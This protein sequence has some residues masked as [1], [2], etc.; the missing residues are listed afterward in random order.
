MLSFI[1]HDL[2]LLLLAALLS[3]TLWLVVTIEQNPSESNWFN[4]VAVE[5]TDL[6]ANFVLRSELPVARVRVSAPRDIWL[7]RGLPTERLKAT[8]DASKVGPGVNDVPIKVVSLEPLAKIEEIDP[9]KMSL[10]IEALKRKEVP[11]RVLTVGTVPLGYESRPPKVTPSEVAISGPQSLVDQVAGVVVE[12]PLDGVRESVSQDYRLAIE[13]E[14]GQPV[15]RVTAIPERVLV[16]VQVDQQLAYKTVSISPRVVGTPAFGYQIVGV[17]V[18]PSTTTIVGDPRA[19]SEITFM[20]TKPID[21]SGVDG[22]V[23]VSAE[24]ALPTGVTLARNQSVLVRVLVNA[25]ESGKLIEV[26]PRI[27]GAGDRTV[28]I[29]PNAVQVEVSGPM[30]LLAKLGPQDLQVVL[31]VT[32]LQPGTHTVK[33]S[34]IVPNL[35]RLVNVTPTEITIIIR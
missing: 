1:K 6:P 15:E 23:A 22:D 20:A 10:R 2:T 19:I 11:V 8:V 7:K 24:P 30:P 4:S 26:A 21:V 33:P 31:D 27:K 18:D 14:A 25:A 28:T 35:I 13:N 34:V 12:V 9:P 29:S 16:E 5:V 3:V 17:M 32:W